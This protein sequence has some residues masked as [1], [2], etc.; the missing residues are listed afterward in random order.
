MKS[1]TGYGRAEAI[2]QGITLT[3]EMKSVNHRFR[4]ISVR[5]PRSLSLFEEQIKKCIQQHI[6]RGRIDTYLFMSSEQWGIRKLN[7]DWSLAEAYVQAA[8]EMKNRLGVSGNITL[9]DLL[10]IP[11]LFVIDERSDAEDLKAVL[12]ET[13]ERA[14]R[15]LVHMRAEEGRQLEADMLERL[16]VI[17][18]ILHRV[19]ECSPQIK[20]A[21]Q[22][23]LRSGVEDFLQNRAELDEA[24][25]M[26]EVAVYL[27]KSNIDEE[28]TR[29][30]SH[31]HQFQQLLKKDEVLGR[32]LDFVLQEMNREVNTLG[33][34]S[35]STTISQSVVN[36][37][38]ELEKLREQVQN[39]E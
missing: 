19:T 20:E 17:K 31:I 34:K 2:V 28:L 3:V 16:L 8:E 32:K 27:D 18:E 33:A 9:Q 10:S 13:V 24:R 1:M 26:N 7:V 14:V 25:L 4:E 29:L 38:S 35:Q 30:D 21:Y 15:D 6:S 39:I 37:K 23:K 12:L 11:E 5:M 22:S 36:L